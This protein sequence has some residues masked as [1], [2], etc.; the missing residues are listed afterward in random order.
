MYALKVLAPVDINHFKS[1][2]H[3][4]NGAAGFRRVLG[5]PV[6]KTDVWARV[7]ELDHDDFNRATSSAE[8]WMTWYNARVNNPRRAPEFRLYYRPEIDGIVSRANPGDILLL[9]RHHSPARHHLQVSVAIA[10]QGSAPA[11]LLSW[12]F[13]QPRDAMEGGSLSH[14]AAHGL[15]LPSGAASA[16]D[17]LGMSLG[18]RMEVSGC[19]DTADSP[20]N[21]VGACFDRDFREHELAFAERLKEEG[22]GPA[23]GPLELFH[24]ARALGGRFQVH[25]VRI[26]RDLLVGEIV[27]AG[28]AHKDALSRD[29]GGVLLRDRSGVWQHTEV[30]PLLDAA[31]LA[32]LRLGTMPRFLVTLQ[33]GLGDSTH[34]MLE[35]AGC[36]IVAPAQ[37]HSAYP[38]EW[39]SQVWSISEWLDA[40]S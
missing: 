22:P 4:F 21:R 26:L 39:R 7:V 23:K 27:R 28:L 36:R 9:L 40:H 5:E 8:T 16:I 35:R 19:V 13:N 14:Q 25:Q 12:A 24:E 11:R 15:S 32:H 2:Q 31:T 30:R 18:L 38:D 6:G 29:E 10:R 1:N 37:L 3:E 34:R 33:P 17:A 20:D